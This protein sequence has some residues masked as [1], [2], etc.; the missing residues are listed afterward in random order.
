MHQPE[1]GGGVR[2]GHATAP[3]KPRE[4][5]ATSRDP[6]EGALPEW[7]RGDAPCQ[8]SGAFRG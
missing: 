1:T 8:G 7:L 3:I 5:R 2:Q 6:S 4:R